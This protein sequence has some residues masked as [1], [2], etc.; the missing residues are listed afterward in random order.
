MAN[1]KLRLIFQTLPAV[2]AASQCS[3]TDFS[4]SHVQL[5]TRA[6]YVLI[7]LLKQLQNVNLKRTFVR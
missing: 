7:N 6:D 1:G 2:Y 3:Y 5:T 4:V